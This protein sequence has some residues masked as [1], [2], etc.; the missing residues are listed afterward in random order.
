M[1][2]RALAL[3][4]VLLAGFPAG[5]AAQSRPPLLTATYV[6]H[7]ARALPALGRLPDELVGELAPYQ[8][9]LF[10]EVHGTREAPRLALELVRLELHAGR[11][12]WLGIELP[13]TEQAELDRF[14]AT[15]DVGILRAMPFFRRPPQLQDGRSSTA[16]AEMLMAVQQLPD[17]PVYCLE[18]VGVTSEQERDTGMAREIARHM[19]ERPGEV[20][21]T[22]TGNVHA[23]QKPGLPWDP[24][25]RPMGYEL[26]HGGLPPARVLSVDLAYEQ[27]TAWNIQ[28]TGN[29][30][31]VGIH[32][33]GPISSVYASAVIWGAYYL[34]LPAMMDGYNAI[35]FWRTL[36]AS[37][38]FI[39]LLQS[40]PPSPPPT[41]M[42]VPLPAASKH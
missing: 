10:G 39:P 21:V 17:I 35:I 37:S 15:E 11:G 27:G 33:L 31:S 14:R 22:L 1:T 13:V 23:S 30:R 34:K 9:I 38:P 25:F 19:M 12:A 3:A 8:A 18:P 36:S 6:R 32:N 20:A 24:S 4:A 29:A 5:V 26:T 42:P 40:P 2:R 7:H 28:G 41:A 16:M